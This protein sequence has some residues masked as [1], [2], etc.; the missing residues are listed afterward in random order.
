MEG[1]HA[2][3][4]NEDFH[5]RSL[6]FL[7]LAETK[8]DATCKSDQ[9]KATLS[10]WI[11]LG[12]FD[13]SDGSKHMGL[14]LLASKQSS[15]FEQLD[16]IDHHKIRRNNELQVQG[17]VI[18]FQTGPVFGFV[19]CRSTPSLSEVST[20]HKQFDKCN[21]LM[22]DF[23]LSHCLAEEKHKIEMLCSG[24]KINSLQEITRSMSNNQLDYILIDEQIKKKSFCDKL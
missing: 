4:L 19:Y 1:G 20:I 12:R 15:I 8:L 3:Y 7:V 18:R 13:A 21:M 11:I 24:K 2:K 6:D 16:S 9:V 17:L 5:L 22:G 23:N 14:M 10:N